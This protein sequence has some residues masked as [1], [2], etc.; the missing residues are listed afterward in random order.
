MSTMLYPYKF[1]SNLSTSSW[2]ILLTR[3]YYTNYNTNADANGIC[4]KKKKSTF[5]MVR[6]HNKMKYA[7]PKPWVYS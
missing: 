5:P 4:T 2:D 7:P 3:K 6:V 1:G